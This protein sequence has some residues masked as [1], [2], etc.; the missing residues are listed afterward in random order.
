MAKRESEARGADYYEAKAALAKAQTEYNKIAN[1][2]R[3]LWR[4]NIALPWGST[5]SDEF[6][7]AERAY[8]SASDLLREARERVRLVQSRLPI[9]KTKPYRYRIRIDSR[10]DNEGEA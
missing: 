8:L 4:E 1:V 5:P 7:R 10:D 6:V 9:R 2:Y 3:P